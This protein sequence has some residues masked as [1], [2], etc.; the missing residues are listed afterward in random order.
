MLTTQNVNI[1]VTQSKVINTYEMVWTSFHNL[2][3]IITP[4][5]AITSSNC[6]Q[7]HVERNIYF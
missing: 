7:N 2:I 3:Y 5:N 4:V 1:K 6:F